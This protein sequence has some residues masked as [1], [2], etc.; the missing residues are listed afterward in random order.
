MTLASYP[1]P[2][3]KAH[4]LLVDAQVKHAIAEIKQALIEGATMALEVSLFSA[5]FRHSARLAYDIF[6]RVLQ[7]EQRQPI[8]GGGGAAAGRY[9]VV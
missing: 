5:L 4:P 9:N 8:G 1:H 6:F 2:R 3:S 7:A